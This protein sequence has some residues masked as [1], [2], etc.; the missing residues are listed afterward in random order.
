MKPQ[1]HIDKM[2]A[3][4]RKMAEEGHLRDFECDATM[5][6]VKYELAHLAELFK[7]EDSSE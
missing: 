1:E 5:G 7:A 2:Y 3:E 4:A 6:A